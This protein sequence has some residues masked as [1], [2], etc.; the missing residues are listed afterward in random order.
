MGMTIR[1]CKDG[2][3]TLVEVCETAQARMVL[4]N[5]QCGD[6][7]MDWYGYEGHDGLTFTSKDSAAFSGM[8]DDWLFVKRANPKR[9]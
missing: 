1:S 3:R 5:I 7:F 8:T 4:E 9:I 6:T 2:L